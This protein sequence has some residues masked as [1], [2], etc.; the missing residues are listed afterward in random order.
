VGDVAEVRSR[1]TL[2]GVQTAIDHR[3]VRA[4]AG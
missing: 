1:P 2:H 3:R 4:G